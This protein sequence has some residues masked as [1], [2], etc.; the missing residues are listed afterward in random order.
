MPSKAERWLA[1]AALFQQDATSGATRFEY[2]VADFR[3]R[4]DRRTYAPTSR[5][6]PWAGSRR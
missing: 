2:D 3:A 6:A 1:M 4:S 5:R